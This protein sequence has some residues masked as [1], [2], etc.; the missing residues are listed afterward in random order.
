MII[1]EKHKFI[2]IKSRKTAGSSI[3]LALSKVCSPTDVIKGPQIAHIDESLNFYQRQLKNYDNLLKINLFKKLKRERL[4]KRHTTLKELKNIIK[5]DYDS[6]FKFAFIRNPWDLVVS[7]YFWDKHRNQHSFDDFNLWLEQNYQ[8]KELWKKDRLHLYTHIDNKFEL[9]F[10]G[11][12]EKLESDFQLVCE[13][14][15]LGK[16]KLGNEK[17]VRQDKKH[18]TEYYSVKSKQIVAEIFKK[19]LEYFNYKFGDN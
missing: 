9:D 1:S 6:Y 14:L 19:D 17:R 11:R 7:R 3:Q 10:V 16:L 5:N 2:F 15:N 13:K 8:P 12:Y 18:Y 4:I